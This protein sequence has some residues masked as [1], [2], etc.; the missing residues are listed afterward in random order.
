MKNNFSKL[1]IF[2]IIIISFIFNLSYSYAKNIEFKSSEI[3]TLEEGDIVVGNK[4]AELTINDTILIS[5]DKYTYYKKKNL[6]IIEGNVR[7]DDYENKVTLIS[8]LIHYNTTKSEIISYGETDV[9]VRSKYKINSYNINYFNN[10]KILSSDFNS[11]FRD[12][13]NNLVNLSKFK[14]FIQEKILSGDQIELLDNNK[15]KYF[16]TKGMVKVEDKIII[17]KDIEILL[18]NNSLENPEN[19]PRLKG[20][21]VSYGKDLT[22]IN[23]GIFTSCKNEGICPPWSITSRRILHNKKKQEISYENAV[24]KIYDKPIIYFPRFFHPD[25]TVKRRS[26]FLAPTFGD[27]RKLGASIII[28]YFH[29]ISDN[30]DLTFQPRIFSTNEFLIR[31]EFRKV[32]KNSSHIMDFS[33]NKNNSAINDGRK[34]HFFSNSKFNLP[35]YNFDK[36]EINLKLEKTSNDNYINLYSL[37]DNKSIVKN[38]SILNNQVGLSADKDDFSLEIAFES[39]ETMN[40]PNSDR[41]EYIYPTYNLSKITIAENN[42]IDNFTISSFGS[43]KKIL[44]NVYE[45]VQINDL[46]INSLNFDNRLGINNNFELLFKNVNTKGKNSPKYK[47]NSQAELLSL[48]KYDLSFPLLKKENNYKNLL[49]PK[50]SLMHSPNDGKNIK[51]EERILDVNN[52]FSSNRIG[53]NDTIEGGTSITVG[54]DFKKEILNGN[55]DY[56]SSNIATV[57]RD[58]QNDNLPYNSSLNQKYSDIVGE[59]NYKPNN[60]LDLKY[61]YSINQDIDEINLHKF[62]N[63]IKINNFVNSFIFYEENNLTGNESY[64]EN[65][66]TYNYNNKNSLSFKMKE[67]KKTNLTEYYNLIYEYKNDCL[68]ASL[69]YNK[70]YYYGNN[71]KPNEQLFFNLTLIPLGSTKTDNLVDLK[72]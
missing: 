52:I 53:F 41:F 37:K 72:N 66:I 54:L 7:A 47:E 19:E 8:E 39:Y 17:G 26:G 20:N 69:R 40:R 16:L 35:I 13:D 1:L 4:N 23:K 61:N 28:P 25:P 11:N 38:S 36:T 64:Y 71:V 2:T 44:T 32:N 50:I 34:T 12:N 27:S 14:Y 70:E 62:E 58:K 22:I 21:S 48:L 15:N 29:V 18:E 68:I 55:K 60:I 30:A 63:T 10:D 59:I 31:S 5:G 42:F 3:F 51:N 6:L 57:I 24:L 46:L 43:Q 65:L 67:N 9:E 33:I 56:F 45:G 49:I